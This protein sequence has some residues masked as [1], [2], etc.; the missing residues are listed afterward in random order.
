LIKSIVIW[1]VAVASTMLLTYPAFAQ[2]NQTLELLEECRELGIADQNCTE[3]AILEHR[4]RDIPL[5][6]QDPPTS[7]NWIGMAAIAAALGGGA[8]FFVLRSRRAR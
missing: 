2:S 6:P 8:S 3:K 1:A 4:P 5:T 7:V